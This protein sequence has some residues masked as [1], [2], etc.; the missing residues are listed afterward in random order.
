MDLPK[1]P[2]L[3]LKMT[4]MV[5]TKNFGLSSNDIDRLRQGDKR[6]QTKVFDKNAPTYLRIVRN[7]WR[8]S[9]EDAED[10][11]C[12][13]FAKLFRRIQEGL[14]DL[15]LSGFV[16]TVVENECKEYAEKQKK[17]IVKPMETLPEVVE[18]ETEN[19][20]LDRLNWAFKQLGAKCQK[21][22][23]DFYW[24]DKDYKEIAEELDIK[25]DAARQRKRECM[26]KMRELMG[27]KSEKINLACS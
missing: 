27:G 26:K 10:I 9:L 1:K 3:K 5:E 24:D 4:N 22:L 23:N 19:A 17:N 18:K 14:S 2:S 25:E 6:L 21:L 8:F 15:N 12:S 11:V 13:A 20:F 7:N 16:F